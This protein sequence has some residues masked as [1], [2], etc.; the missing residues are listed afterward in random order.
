MTNNDV[1]YKFLVGSFGLAENEAIHLLEWDESSKQ[2]REIAGTKGIEAPSYLT[3]DAERKMCYAMLISFLHHFLWFF[4]LHGTNILAGVIEPI[5]LPFIERNADL[6]ARGMS[7][8]DVPYIITKPFF[9]VFVYMGGAGTSIALI[10]AVFIVIQQEKNY[11]YREISKLAAPAGIFNINEPIIFGIPIVFN[12]IF[13]V[14]FIVGPVV[15]TITSYIALASGIV[16]KTVA[17]LP[18]T[19]PPFISGYL[20]TGGSWRGTALQIINLGISVMLYLPFVMIGVRAW[21]NS[22]SG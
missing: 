2:I 18:W 16:P 21:K 11:P 10:V 12:P 7:A 15:L 9:D 5:Y 13:F 3:Y 14:P 17:F 6:F 1:K 4:G 22:K 8:Y 19:T 20:V